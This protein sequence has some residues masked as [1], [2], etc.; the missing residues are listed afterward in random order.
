MSRNRRYVLIAAAALV[1]LLAIFGIV[2]YRERLQRHRVFRPVAGETKKTETPR[3]IPPVEQWSATFRQ[4][5]GDD[6]AELLEQ[7]EQK[8]PDLYARHSLAYLHAR[9]LI[10]SNEKSDAAKKLEPFLAK[11]NPLRELALYHR[12]SIADGEDASRY[13]MALITDYPHALYRD[14]AIED[15]IDYL[16]TLDDPNRLTQFATTITPSASTAL[17]R[18]ITARILEAT[19]KRDPNGA[20][21]RGLALLQGGTS[22]DAADRAARALDR[23]ELLPRMNVNQWAL[24]GETFQKHR[25]FD[26]A[27]ALLQ[28]ALK[29]AYTDDLQ[30]AVG[31]SYFGAE[32]F[33][34][35]QAAYLRGANATKSPGQKATFL[36]HAARSVQ[37]RGDDGGAEQLMS[38][39]IAVPGKFPATLAALTQRLRTRAKQHRL[40]EAGADLAQLRKLA[41]NERAIVEGSLAYAIALLGTGNP[42]GATATL[43]GVPPKLLD[44]YDRAE[45]AYWRA[46]AAEDRDPPAAFRNYLDVL[47]A[48]V[49]THFAYFARQRLDAP[50]MAPKLTRELAL[51]EAQ[52]A[53]LIAAKNFATAKQ[54]QTD[55]VLLSS[56]D[57]A[58]QLQK[59][60]A[61][62]RELPAYRAILELTPESLPQFPNAATPQDQLLAMGLYD[63]AVP[64]IEKRWGLRPARAA[65]TRSLALNQG[66]A[67]KDSIYA[68]EVMMKSVPNDF[69][70][71]LL[72]E[73]VRQL[74]Y[75]RYFYNYIADDAKKY[76]ADP[77]LVLS[78][79]RE[80]SRFNPRAKS[81]AAA[82]GLL[83]FIITTA[84]DIGR[85]VG[86][87]DLAPEDLYDPRV[88]IRLGAKYISELSKTFGG[89][90]YRASAAYNA[91]PKQVALWTRLQPAPGDDYFLSAIN[92]DETKNY[93]RKVMNSYER[94]GAI[95]GSSAPVGGLRA[96][97]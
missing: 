50:A 40:A 33:A 16:S 96:E 34:E 74:L 78:I 86:I 53:N 12:A 69:H 15:E 18:D 44:D 56:R 2:L 61:I 21:T 60:A 28:L 43:N 4:L 95:Y 45:F 46:R 1:L 31:R 79:M 84:R 48:K 42:A 24:L 71:D 70:P 54:L 76:E 29:H 97:P 85:D 25:H 6:L 49:P 19:A 17:R 68:I 80:E 58:A 30:F 65:L 59:L 10:E 88:I 75:P 93:V 26:R 72:P 41:P 73:V 89:D 13:R 27:T 9:A 87:V 90:H 36:W 32:K 66:G 7:I 91:G 55:R 5:D 11:G 77:A 22:D 37:L 23:P 3:G 8:Q 57:R 62:Y 38:Q 82:R 94:Y 14:E 20:L 39:A 51:R 63:D 92:F 47:R 64:S 52:V 35:A 81:E 83:Q 67:S